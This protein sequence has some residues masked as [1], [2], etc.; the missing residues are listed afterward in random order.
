[1]TRFIIKLSNDLLILVWC[2]THKQAEQH[3]RNMAG[4]HHAQVLSIE[5]Q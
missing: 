4:L 2:Y 3:A 1:M 5:E